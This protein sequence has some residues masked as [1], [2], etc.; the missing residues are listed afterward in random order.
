MYTGYLVYIKT[1]LFLNM[2]QA[3]Y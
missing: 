2:K 1:N 3:I